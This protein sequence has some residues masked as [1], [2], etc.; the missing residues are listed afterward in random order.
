MKNVNLLS[1]LDKRTKEMENNV[2]LGTRTNLGWAELTY[3]GLSI[4][5]K[6]IGSY[7]I[8][9]GMNKGDKVAILS[10]SMPEFG[11]AIFGSVLAGMTIV[12]LD[13]KLT[14]HEYEHIL[15]DCLPRVILTSETYLEKAK[16]I[17]NLISSIEQIVVIDGKKPEADFPN[18]YALQ[19]K[20]QKWRH[21]RLDET[22]IIFLS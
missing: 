9:T 18:L 15:N 17:K 14:I 12:P 8:E 7:L 21:K 1:F 19:T 2:A 22:A 3:K 10:E 16:N 4:L 20:E 13:I 11:A 5:S 6:K